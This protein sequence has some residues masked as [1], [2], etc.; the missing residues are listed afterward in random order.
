MNY[1]VTIIKPSMKNIL[2]VFVILACVNSCEIVDKDFD[3]YTIMNETDKNLTII[4]YDKYYYS[5]D[6]VLKVDEPYMTDSINLSS[7]EKHTVEKR[8]GEDNQPR[9]FFKSGGEDSV[10]VLFNN[11]R[12][13]IYVCHKAIN[14][15]CS[16]KRNIMNWYEYSTS[17]CE[18]NRGCDYIY[19]ITEEDYLEAEPI[20]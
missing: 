14:S 8:T 20:E 5:G 10:I 2:F 3:T 12:R 16:D 17:T 4:A 15:S 7:Y 13:L 18:K 9:G 19:K 6:S 1:L 11:E